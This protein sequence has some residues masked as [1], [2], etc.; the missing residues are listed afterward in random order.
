MRFNLLSI[1]LFVATG[2]GTGDSIVRIEGKNGGVQ[3]F[4]LL[5]VREN[6]L[7][8]GMDLIDTVVQVQTVLKKDIA[9]LYGPTSA[10]NTWMWIGIGVGFLGSGVAV[11]VAISQSE[12]GGGNGAPLAFG[13][14]AIPSMVVGGLL[15]YMIPSA[16][17]EYDVQNSEDWYDLREQSVYPDGEPPELYDVR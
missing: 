4:K 10:K 15:G 3:V 7:L 11:N 14:L 16:E 1:L 2:C 13:L 12:Q 6:A 17:R 8:V 5:A 9:K